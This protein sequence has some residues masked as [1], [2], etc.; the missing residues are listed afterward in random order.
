M[1]T[2]KN[3]TWEHS[4]TNFAPRCLAVSCGLETFTDL[5][6]VPSPVT[7]AMPMSHID[8]CN[9]VYVELPL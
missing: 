1:L 3:P 7:H 5:P 6:F 9:M 8:Y 2:L 4:W